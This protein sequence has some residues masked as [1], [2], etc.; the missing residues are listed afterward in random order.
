MLVSKLQKGLG[1]CG[2]TGIL[3]PKIWTEWT[4]GK[5]VD[6]TVAGG[7]IQVSLVLKFQEKKTTRTD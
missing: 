4:K 1:S 7:I 2:N 5:D 3:S 6:L